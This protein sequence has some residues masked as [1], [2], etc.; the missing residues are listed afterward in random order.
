MRMSIFRGVAFGAFLIT[1]PCV[2]AKCD[3][4]QHLCGNITVETN[5]AATIAKYVAHTLKN[6]TGIASLANLYIER[7]ENRLCLC[8]LCSKVKQRRRMSVVGVGAS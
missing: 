8:P 1:F 6:Q 2:G 5:P 3:P 7:Q 4:E